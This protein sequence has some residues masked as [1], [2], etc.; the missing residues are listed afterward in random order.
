MGSEI[1]TTDQQQ[2]RLE[3]MIEEFRAAQLR[4]RLKQGIALWNRT[5][6]QA[7]VAEKPPPP[8]TLN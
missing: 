6:G 7:A 2:T 3:F 8:E 4:R 5:V 1:E